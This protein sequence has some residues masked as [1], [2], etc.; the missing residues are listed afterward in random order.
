MATDTVNGR[1]KVRIDFDFLSEFL[2][3]PSDWKPV[4]VD[5]TESGTIVLEVEG[6][7]IE[8][9]KELQCTM[10]SRRINDDKEW[11]YQ[12]VWTMNDAE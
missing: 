4:S 11:W 10:R 7:D 12:S 5:L 1:A 9:G 2:R 3:M 6:W 8:N